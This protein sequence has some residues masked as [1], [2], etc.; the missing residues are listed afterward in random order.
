M[1]TQGVIMRTVLG[2]E[3]L[4][5]KDFI[6]LTFIVASTSNYD[7]DVMSSRNYAEPTGTRLVEYFLVTPLM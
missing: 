6:S 4:G 3:Q 5:V 7:L 2:G 1:F